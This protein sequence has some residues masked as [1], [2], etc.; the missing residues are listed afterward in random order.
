MKKLICLVL[1]LSLCLAGCKKQGGGQ[2]T[3]QASENIYKSVIEMLKVQSGF[4]SAS[5][6]NS[7][8]LL[9]GSVAVTAQLM[10]DIEKTM[11]SYQPIG[12]SR[13][14]VPGDGQEL[15][16]SF[17]DDK[18]IAL[19]FYKSDDKT[20]IWLQNGQESSQMSADVQLYNELNLLLSGAVVEA[21]PVIEGEFVSAQL[22]SGRDIPCGFYEKNGVLAAGYTSFDNKGYVDFYSTESGEL[23]GTLELS[24]GIVRLDTG[25]DGSAR[26]FV[27]GAV[28]YIDVVKQK[29]KSTFE[30]KEKNTD[31]GDSF[32]INEKLKI[33][34]YAKNGVVYLCDLKG[35]NINIIMEASELSRALTADVLKIIEEEEAFLYYASPRFAGNTVSA[36]ARCNIEAYPQVG[37]SSLE[38]PAD[39]LKKLSKQQL[40]QQMREDYFVINFPSVFGKLGSLTGFEG[41]NAIVKCD[42]GTGVAN[43]RTGE[44]WLMPTTPQQ[45]VVPIKN[46]MLCVQTVNLTQQ[47]VGNIIEVCPI[48]NTENRT[49]VLTSSAAAL[50]IEGSSGNT[51]VIKDATQAQLMFINVL[52][53]Q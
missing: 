48:T 34:A 37:M 50:S 52:H 42:E 17:G 10:Q 31:A 7:R 16:L 33:C 36:V 24:S 23:K 49:V 47:G 1:I 26:V 38:L 40:E 3:T 53:E 35:E 28:H 30:L 4:V 11:S 14:H 13:W 8:Q 5:C 18:A 45:R 25:F 9:H 39:I 46:N 41:E 20:I 19:Q 2:V 51:L 22:L 43:M 6:P 32:D 15:K 44:E 27:R 21:Q 12:I 29:I